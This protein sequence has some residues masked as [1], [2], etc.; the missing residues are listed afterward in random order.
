MEYCKNESNNIKEK[1]FYILKPD[2]N[3]INENE[4]KKH[5]YGKEYQ[6]I[7]YTELYEALKPRERKNKPS[8]SE[9]L[10]D[11]FIQ[12]LEYVKS[13]KAEQMRKTAYIRLKQK[14]NELKEKNPNN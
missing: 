11:Q 5:E 7:T 4:L 1:H 8:E 12:S 3:P 14:I 6:I 13:S 10:Y 9:F 2:Y